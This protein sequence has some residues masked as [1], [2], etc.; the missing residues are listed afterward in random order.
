MPDSISENQNAP[1]GNGES[2]KQ[3]DSSV[4]QVLPAVAKSEPPPS[5]PK[6]CKPH[7]RKRD[8]FDYGKGILEIAGLVVL[9]VYAAYTIKIYRANKKAAD[10]AKES[11]HTSA[12]TMRLDEK[13]WLIF[14]TDYSDRLK[15]RKSEEIFVPI[16]LRDIGKTP[17][18]KIDGF[19]VIE[20]LK[21]GDA[22]RFDKSIFIPLR[23]G[24]IWPEFPQN[25]MAMERTSEKKPVIATSQKMDQYAKGDL[26]FAVWGRIT[27]EDIFHESHWTQF[28]HTISSKP[29][30]HS[31][32]CAD[33]NEIDVLTS[34]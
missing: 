18:R 31:K 30:A 27:Y 19:V 4:Q 33:Y 16:Q 13:A 20:E 25:T 1:H 10:A 28:C 34:Q 15:L 24:I 11:S 14:D 3:P 32:Q 6:C 29:S 21:T 2:E 12:V 26:A 8:W 17:A 22:P 5:H 9:C 7:K 23:A